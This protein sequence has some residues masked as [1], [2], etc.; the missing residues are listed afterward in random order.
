MPQDIGDAKVFL[1]YI[2]TCPVD[3]N[4]DYR[5]KHWSAMRFVSARYGVV[6]SAFLSTPKGII[7]Y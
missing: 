2:R 5:R 6:H 4:R 7:C 1:L 3:W